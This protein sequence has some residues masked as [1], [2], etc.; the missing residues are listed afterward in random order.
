MENRNSESDTNDQDGVEFEEWFNSYANISDLRKNVE[1]SKL[2]GT[3]EAEKSAL[4]LELKAAEQKFDLETKNTQKKALT[5]VQVHSHLRV[6]GA[7]LEIIQRKPPRS[8]NLESLKFE[9]EEKYGKEMGILAFSKS[10]LDTLF[11]RAN[12]ALKDK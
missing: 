3:S 10:S 6:M 8:F 12:K 4:Y 1:K 2:D 9:L 11:A 5:N 7:L